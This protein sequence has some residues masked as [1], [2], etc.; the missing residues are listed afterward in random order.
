MFFPHRTT[1]YS[2]YS[3]ETYEGH[4]K[5]LTVRTTRTK[6]AMAIVFFHPQV[7]GASGCLSDQIM[8]VLNPNICSPAQ[9]LDEEEVDALKDSMRKHFTEGEGK[10]SGVTSLHFVREGQR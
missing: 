5:Q 7:R 8:I 9:K 10:D 2:V 4:W 1:P 3:P 6:E